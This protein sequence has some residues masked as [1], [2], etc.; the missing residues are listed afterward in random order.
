MSTVLNNHAHDFP[1]NGCV[2][3]PLKIQTDDFLSLAVTVP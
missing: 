3:W 2:R 1:Q